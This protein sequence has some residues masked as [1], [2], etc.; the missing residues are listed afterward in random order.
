[1]D[2]KDILLNLVDYEDNVTKINVVR[3]DSY[4]YAD[5]SICCYL[6]YPCS[7]CGNSFQLVQPDNY[8]MAGGALLKEA[9]RNV[10][11]GQTKAGDKVI[12]VCE[13]CTIDM[14]RRQR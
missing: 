1:V 4:P 8:F 10:Q 2:P 9:L 13:S 5:P 14:L 6:S 3:L 7:Y 12:G 11:T